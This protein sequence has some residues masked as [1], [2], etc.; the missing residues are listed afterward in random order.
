MLIPVN[1][2]R[3][4]FEF[5]I[6]TGPFKGNF[7]RYSVVKKR[8]QFE[9]IDPIT[10]KVLRKGVSKLNSHYLLRLYYERAF[11]EGRI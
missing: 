11:D 4:F 10:R 2:T 6:N 3:G 7:I 9:I 8:W 1:H 5:I